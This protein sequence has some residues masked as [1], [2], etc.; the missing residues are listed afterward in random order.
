M[1]EAPIEEFMETKEAFNDIIQIKHNNEIYKL[2]IEVE[3]YMMELTIK[4]NEDS[5]EEY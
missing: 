3:D 2:N 4:E 1:E 5:L